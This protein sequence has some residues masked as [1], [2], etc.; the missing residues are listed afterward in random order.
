MRVEAVYCPGPGQVDTT[1]LE[2]AAG[3]TLA[4]A[5]AES[6]LLQRHGLVLET[7]QAGVWSRV[8]PLDTVLRDNDRVEIYRPLTVDP[9][10]ARRLRYKRQRADGKPAPAGTVATTGSRRR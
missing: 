10:E 8:K 7:V 6:G 1:V 3:T 2:L 9:K 4:Q 5:L